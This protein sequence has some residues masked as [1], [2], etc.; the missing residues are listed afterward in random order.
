MKIGM[1][2]GYNQAHYKLPIEKILRAEK[3][4][5]DS[6]WSAEAYGSEAFTPLAYVAALTKKLRLGTAIAQLAGRTPANLAMVAQTLDALAGEGRVIVGLGVSGPQVVEGWHGQPW[7]KPA[8]RLRDYVAIAKKIWRREE[9]VTH[10][11]RE[12]KLPYS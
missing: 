2:I 10:D 6:V 9:P 3:L 4:G 8:D 1:H 7:G 5:F 12:Y 11:G